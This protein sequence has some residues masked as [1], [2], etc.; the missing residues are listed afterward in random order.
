MNHGGM[1]EWI[2]A[3]SWS[4]IRVQGSPDKNLP[5]ITIG[6]LVLGRDRQ[7]DNQSRAD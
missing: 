2:D 5:E 7:Y 3:A 6:V 4:G 1:H